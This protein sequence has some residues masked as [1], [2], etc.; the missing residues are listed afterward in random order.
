MA[1]H[2]QFTPELRDWLLHNLDRGVPPAPLARALREQ[3]LNSTLAD[4]L[5]LVFWHARAM[6]IAPPA[7]FVSPEQLAAARYRHAAPRLA[8]GNG[9]GNDVV[10]DGQRIR[11]AMQVEQPQVTVLDD[12][13]SA[14]E[15]DALMALAQPRLRPSTIVDPLTGKDT[16]S[17]ARSSE[18]MFFK[19]GE[20]PLVGRLDARLSAL[21]N[22]P[23]ENGEGLQ[24]LRYRGGEQSVPHY[25]FLMAN[26]P[27]NVASLARSGQRVSTLIVYLND[28]KSG[29]QT[30]FPESGLAVTP[31]RGGALYFEY[32]NNDGQLDPQSLHAALPV[33]AG[34]K[35]IVTKWMRQRRFVPA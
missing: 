17:A 22:L 11:L 23:V 13:F 30:V 7:E 35:W 26:N 3:G 33:L 16:V 31:R 14:A 29:G 21:M 32:C 25:D 5:A 6:G 8:I 20:T 27:A 2:I 10:V 12:V 15:C 24:V 28:V 19:L 34:E 9:G 4:D 1:D 18:G